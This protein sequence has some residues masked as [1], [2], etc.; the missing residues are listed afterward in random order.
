MASSLPAL[1]HRLRNLKTELVAEV[2]KEWTKVVN[3]QM[4]QCFQQK[5][6]P[7]GKP[8]P[9]ELVKTGRL[10]RSLSA[11][12]KKPGVVAIVMVPYGEFYRSWFLPE[13][14]NHA[15]DPLLEQV[16]LLCLQKH[17]EKK[18]GGCC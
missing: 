8:W 17:L 16:I 13:E 12:V 10:Q 2:S 3:R 5:R 9:T 4:K 7:A 15:W 18:T 1:A 6:S 11:V 14:G